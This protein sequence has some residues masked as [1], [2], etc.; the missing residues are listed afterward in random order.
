MLLPHIQVLNMLLPQM[1]KNSSKIF[2][3]SDFYFSIL[4]LL[5]HDSI[6]REKIFWIAVWVLCMTCSWSYVSYLDSVY[7]KLFS[8]VHES[9]WR[10]TTSA[11][12]SNFI[13]HVIPFVLVCCMCIYACVSIYLNCVYGYL[14][15]IIWQ[16][17]FEK[18]IVGI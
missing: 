3:L 11:F 13:R 17:H 9:L 6:T 10:E 7:Y 12:Q 14:K 18:G 2:I 16:R 4:I 5:L 1:L 8:V 15:D